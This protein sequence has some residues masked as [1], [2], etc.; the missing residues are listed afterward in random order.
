MP[1]I[2]LAADGF[3]V[4]P[5]LYRLWLPP[6]EYMRGFIE[7]SDGL[8]MLG[9]SEVSRRIYLHPDGSVYEIGETLVQTDYARTLQRIADQGPD[10]FSRPD[11]RVEGPV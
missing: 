5:Y 3:E 10:E 11:R 1:A 7:G 2:R 4:Y 9:F 6:S 8:G